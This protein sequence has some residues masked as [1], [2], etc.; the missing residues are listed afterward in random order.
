MFNLNVKVLR[1]GQSNCN[2]ALNKKYSIEY[3]SGGIKL[4][5]DAGRDDAVDE[6]K[7]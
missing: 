4:K 2:D 5:K 6:A 3:L 1:L 7:E